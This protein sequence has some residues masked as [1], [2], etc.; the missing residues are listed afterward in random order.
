MS[1]MQGNV[2]EPCP[3]CGVESQPGMSFCMHCGTSLATQATTCSQIS[4]DVGRPCPACGKV[5]YLSNV[6]CVLCGAD[7]TFVS[8]QLEAQMSAPGISGQ[9]M[10]PG[11]W[12]DLLSHHHFL[13]ATVTGVLLGLPLALWLVNPVL[14]K[15]VVRNNW[16]RS[17]LVVYALPSCSQVVL[18]DF[19][20][21]RFMLGQ[22]GPAGSLAIPDITP[23]TYRLTLAHPGYKSLVREINIESDNVMVLGFPKRIEL[24]R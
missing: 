23:G 9:S 15:T 5:D 2:T 12:L 6:F 18:E 24:T 8:Q 3:G 1:Q 14:E 7:M 17:G 20:G 4:E 16:P 21:A 19:S 22:T 11:F 13:L 10:K